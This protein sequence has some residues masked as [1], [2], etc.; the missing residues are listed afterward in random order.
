MYPKAVA[1]LVRDQEKLFTFF[2]FPAEHWIHLHTTNPVEPSFS[3]VRL[4][5][6]VTKGGGSRT[7]ELFRKIL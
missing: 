7:K 5:Q 4:R 1:S 3:T 2:D 6:R